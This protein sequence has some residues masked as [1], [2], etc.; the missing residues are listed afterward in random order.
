[1]KKTITL[2]IITVTSLFVVSVFHLRE[3][4]LY[5]WT[6]PL[7]VVPVVFAGYNFRRAGS[8]SMM[9]V[10]LLFQCP[11][12][13]IQFSRNIAWGMNCLVAD[14]T[15]C[16]VGVLIGH[17]LRRE[18]EN[19]VMMRQTQEV[20]ES[21]KRDA[22][23]D[24][25]LD[26]LE[27]RFR[28]RAESELVEIYLFDAGGELRLRKSDGPALPGGHLFYEVAAGSEPLISMYTKEDGRFHYY[29]DG[30]KSGGITQFAVFPFEYGGAARGAIAVGN[31]AGDRFNREMV[32][33]L[34]A[35]KRSFENAMELVEKRRATIE[36]EIK[37]EK[38]RDTFSSYVS[39]AVAEEILKDPDKLDLGGKLQDVTV[40]FTEVI[41]FRELMK[42]G[43]PEELLS[44]LNEFFSIAIETVFE[45]DGTLDKFIGDNVMAFWG[46][47]LPVSDGEQRA[48][49][50]AVKLQERVYVMNG[51]RERRGRAPFRLCIGINSGKAVAGNIGSIR[52]ME[53]TIIGDTVNVA[54]RIKSLSGTMDVPVL[55]SE[56]T[57]E[58]VKDEF[59]CD[60]RLD[61]EIKGKTVTIPVYRLEV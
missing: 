56:S 1:M 21:V 32:S 10:V 34:T 33:F 38:I 41:N 3:W 49:R 27:E 59:K 8:V 58:K 17:V 28:E 51:K 46:A 23:L 55:V 19:A 16:V 50:C 43:D 20:V 47:P 54:S 45:H 4:P 13:T 39:R 60:R 29:G 18:R 61:A 40:M 37:R 22:G 35:V 5:E 11:V 7:L 6:R 24:A 31:F 36:H 14:L 53:Y 48:V 26:A 42:A 44:L 25:L 57:Y 52:R 9:T 30:D 12:I 15:V 2:V